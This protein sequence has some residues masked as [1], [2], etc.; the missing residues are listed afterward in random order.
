MGEVIPVGAVDSIRR[1]YRYAVYEH[2]LV[3]ADGMAYTRSFI[4]L[5]NKYGAI[6]RF[7]KLHRF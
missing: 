4:V 6:V 7:T 3:S 1:G 5:K 2:R